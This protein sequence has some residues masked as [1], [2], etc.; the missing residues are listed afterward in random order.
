MI[1]KSFIVSLLFSFVILLSYG[2]E[3]EKKEFDRTVQ[4]IRNEQHAMQK[5]IHVL[6]DS[7]ASLK[8]SLSLKQG[9]IDSMKRLCCEMSISDDELKD[10]LVAANDTLARRQTDTDARFLRQTLFFVLVF[11][12]VL[13]VTLLLFVLIRRRIRHGDNTIEEIRKAQ[14]RIL[15]ES[16]RLD[17]NLL[18]LMESKSLASEA[19]PDHSMVM[20]MADEIARI[21]MN[22]SRMD[23]SVKGYRQ[24]SKAVERIKDNFAAQGYEL[25]DM[26]G[27][28]YDEGMRINADFVADESL[29]EGTRIITSIVKPQINFKGQMIQKA[30]VTISQNI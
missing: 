1:R 24:L 12:I 13:L 2:Q 7:V 26:L 22:L 18:Q 8:E 25:V 6:A 17:Q 9:E 30:T 10:G 28:T 20:K 5:S 4:R 3:V 11:V 16:I 15:E 23:K 27:M 19:A 21:E 29:P 14:E